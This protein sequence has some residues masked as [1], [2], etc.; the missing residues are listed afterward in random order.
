MFQI[1]RQRFSII[2]RARERE[3][4]RAAFC[5]GRLLV[6]FGGVDCSCAGLCYLSSL[7]LHI[8]ILMSV[9]HQYCSLYPIVPVSQRVRK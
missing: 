9:S 2:K 7:Q 3:R 5:D 8:S 6:Q 4:E 1:E